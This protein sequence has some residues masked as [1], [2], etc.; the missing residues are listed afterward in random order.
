[1]LNNIVNQQTLLL[2][3]SALGH[4]SEMVEVTKEERNSLFD[5]NGSQ[6]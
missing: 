5:V 6:A 4:R 2:K 1:M 3:E